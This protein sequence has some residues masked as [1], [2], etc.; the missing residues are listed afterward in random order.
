MTEGRLRRPVARA[1]LGLGFGGLFAWL[2]M[3]GLDWRALG[4][5]MG[6]ADAAALGLSLACVGLA[7]WIKLLRWRWMLRTMGLRCSVGQCAVPFFVGFAVNN[8]LPLRAGDLVRL[9]AAVRWLRLPPLSVLVSMVLERIA[10]TAVL[11][12]LL[13]L[14]WWGSSPQPGISPLME[15]ILAWGAGLS[16]AGLLALPLAAWLLR[17]LERSGRLAI[18]QGEAIGTVI[19]AWVR[20]GPLFSLGAWSVLAWTLEGAAFVVVA[21]ALGLQPLTLA[22]WALALGTLG[23]LVP[24]GPGHLGT[25]DFFVMKV[26]VVMGVAQANAA[27]YALLTHAVLW[28]PVTLAGVLSWW[29]LRHRLDPEDWRAVKP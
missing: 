29:F 1:L 14:L 24:G 10:D 15:R 4:R 9:A 8:V 28:L 27:A 19:S 13:L 22:W 26:L 11:L 3:H 12:S 20:L 17:K 16:A 18:L 2:F 23:T 25:F 5:V 21:M 6:S 7:Y